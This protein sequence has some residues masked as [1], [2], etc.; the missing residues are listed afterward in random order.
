[1]KN[2]KEQI[3]GKGAVGIAIAYASLR[4]MVNLPLE[5]C[6]YNLI[7]DDGIN[8]FRV[9]VV[10]CSYKNPS[11]I[12]C[13]SIR[14]MG[15]NMPKQTSKPFD[16]GVCDV[17]FVVTDMLD[18]FWIPSSKIESTKQISLSVYS[19]YEVKMALT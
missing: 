7:F 13:A 4:G 18:L 11:G 2:M 6:D 5:P 9:K 19:T 14:T 8:L 12:Y 3:K 16:K 17:V 10:S 1:M 15:G